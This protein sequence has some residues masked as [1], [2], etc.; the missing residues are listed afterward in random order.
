MLKYLK[1][2]FKSRVSI[3]IIIF[4][5][6]TRNRKIY[7]W[8][9]INI[10]S[11]PTLI[12][13]NEPGE[14]IRWNGTVVF[15]AII[16]ATNDIFPT[17]THYFLSFGPHQSRWLLEPVRI[18]GI[19]RTHQ[20]FNYYC[21]LLSSMTFQFFYQFWVRRKLLNWNAVQISD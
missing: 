16:S 19:W 1:L 18:S 12:R 15:A 8:W 11:T 5:V 4:K 14:P 7:S 3:I 21:S 10:R 6:N 13:A 20:L 17:K 2:K 9:S